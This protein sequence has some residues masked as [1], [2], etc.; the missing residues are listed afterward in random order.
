MNDNIT[1]KLDSI[2]LVDLKCGDLYKV[3]LSHDF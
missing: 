1:I 3:S 2:I